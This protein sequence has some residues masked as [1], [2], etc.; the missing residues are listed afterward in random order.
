MTHVIRWSPMRSFPCKILRTHRLRLFATGLCIL[1]LVLTILSVYHY[2]EDRTQVME[3]IDQRLYA[4][5]TGLRYAVGEAFHNRSI[6]P[7]L[8]L[9]ED[10]FQA[11]DTLVHMARDLELKNLCTL[12]SVDDAL[13]QIL[14]SD[15]EEPGNGVYSHFF[16]L[17]PDANKEGAEAHRGAVPRYYDVDNEDSN[18]RSVLIPYVTSGGYRYLVGAS[19][20]ISLNHALAETLQRALIQCGILLLLSFPLTALY[21]WPLLCQLY[22]HELTGLPNRARLKKDL[23]SCRLP[24]LVLIDID[25]FKDINHYYGIQVGDQLLISVANCLK[26]LIPAGTRLYKLDGDEYALLCES[27]PRCISVDYLISRINEQRINI[28]DTEFRLSVTAG[29][30]QGTTQ[31]IEH[32]DLALKEAKRV[33]KPYKHYSSYL[34]TVQNSQAN[35]LWTYKL[36]DAIDSGRIEAYFQPIYDNTQHKISHYETL[37]RLIE[38]DGTVVGPTFFMEAARRSRVYSQL[39]LFVIDAALRFIEKH[40][41]ACTVNLLNED[42]VVDESRQQIIDLIRKESAREKLIFEIV[43]SEGIDNYDT[44][45]S[46]IDQVRVYGVRVAIDDFGTGYS[47]FDHISHLD[48]DYVK[49][50]GSLIEQLNSSARSKTIVEAIIHFA[51]E[52]E[53]ETIAE[54]VSDES[55]QKIVAEMG[56]DYS[57]GYFIGRPQPSDTIGE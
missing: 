29:V 51:K 15:C 22:T 34:H 26:A 53:I 9:K 2:Y 42:I 18:Y 27:S 28:E 47:N 4:G 48:V 39:T 5:A 16:S 8:A 17:Y 56:I 36:K 7:K 35:L 24:Q 41:M 10:Y 57:Q 6:Q 37:V 19:I 55:L 20:D 1:M 12:I 33:L 45:K 50:D 13:Y 32:A 3:K 30:S 54:Y 44:I 38:E 43:E 21:V 11:N 23:T 46:F 25:G 31:L 49:I 52:L 14:S 40:D